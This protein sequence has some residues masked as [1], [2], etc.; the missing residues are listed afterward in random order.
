MVF[1]CRKTLM[2]SLKEQTGI[3]WKHRKK[4]NEKQRINVTEVVT[5]FYTSVDN[6]AKA[7]SISWP[8]ICVHCMW[9]PWKDNCMYC[10]DGSWMLYVYYQNDCAGVY[11]LEGCWVMQCSSHL[12]GMDHS[13]RLSRRREVAAASLRGWSC[14]TSPSHAALGLGGWSWLQ[15]ACTLNT[16]ETGRPKPGCPPSLRMPSAKLICDTRC[17]DLF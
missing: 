9:T 3:E 13:F 15:T 12:H 1:H 6:A 14:K 4:L 8:P 17:V 5:R 2:I 10:I 7:K 16:R 11:W